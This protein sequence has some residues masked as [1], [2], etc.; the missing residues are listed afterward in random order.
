[1]TTSG[2]TLELERSV[3]LV[4]CQAHSGLVLV[5]TQSNVENRL[6]F[7]FA[8][9]CVIVL[10]AKVKLVKENIFPSHQQIRLVKAKLVKENLSFI[11]MSI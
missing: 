9:R 4:T 8:V 11:H 5:M 10:L 3:E 2:E 1:M 6:V 7:V